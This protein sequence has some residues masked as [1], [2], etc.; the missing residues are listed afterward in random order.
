[1]HFLGYVPEQKLANLYQN[2]FIYLY[3]A[4]EEDFGMGVV[5]AMGYAKPVIAWNHAGPSRIITHSVDGYLVNFKNTSEVLQYV[6]V[7][8]N[9]PRIYSS[10]C[11]NAQNT[12]RNRFSWE[13]N[14]QIMNESIQELLPKNTIVANPIVEPAFEMIEAH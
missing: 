2:C 11:Q 8:L 4:P 13:R 12:V 3:T 14:R 9:E 10:I 1:V 5:E 7:L 6:H